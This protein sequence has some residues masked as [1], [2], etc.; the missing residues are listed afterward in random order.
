MVFPMFFLLQH[1]YTSRNMSAVK[2]CT[3]TT[4]RP[5]ISIDS[6]DALAAPLRIE[7]I[8]TRNRDRGGL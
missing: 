2:L 3:K 7:G 6:C 4:T 8:M 1:S 5:S